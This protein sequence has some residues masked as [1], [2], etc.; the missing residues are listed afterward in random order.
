MSSARGQY[1]IYSL[2]HPCTDISTNQIAKLSNNTVNG[3]SYI[4]EFI[5]QL[6]N[7]KSAVFEE[8]PSVNQTCVAFGI[9]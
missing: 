3:D 2:F 8:K 5:N 7:L 6:L 9:K 4:T 1:C